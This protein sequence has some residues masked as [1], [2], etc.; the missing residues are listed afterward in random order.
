MLKNDNLVINDIDYE[1]INLNEKLI[2]LKE[3]TNLYKTNSDKIKAIKDKIKLS[4]K[5]SKPEEVVF[6]FNRIIKL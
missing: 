1:S 6:N 5:N 2:S 4:S 3:K